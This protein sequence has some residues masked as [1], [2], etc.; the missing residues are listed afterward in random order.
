LSLV[1]RRRS[2]PRRTTA[3]RRRVHEA[4]YGRG[5]PLPA[6]QYRFA[7]Q[8]L[9]PQQVSLQVDWTPLLLVGG[10]ILLIWLLGRK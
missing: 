6:R 2:P 9:T 3:E 7:Q 5:A 10:G 1:L 8:A 4:L